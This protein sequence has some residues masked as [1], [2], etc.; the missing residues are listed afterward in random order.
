[1][2]V[3]K[4]AD[5][6]LKQLLVL[7]LIYNHC[8]MNMQIIV[9]VLYK[10]PN[11]NWCDLLFLMLFLLG[12]LDFHVIYYK[13]QINLKL[14]LNYQH[15]FGIGTEGERMVCVFVCEG[16]QAEGVYVIFLSIS[17]RWVPVQRESQQARTNRNT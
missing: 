14:Y 11:A 8:F 9:L 15:Y 7:S 5:S 12:E 13:W 6:R 4:L 10:V 16:G 17:H 2:W 3:L 1:M